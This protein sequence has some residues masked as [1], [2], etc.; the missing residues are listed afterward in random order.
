MRSIDFAS[1]YGFPESLPAEAHADRTTP[2][3]AAK[4]RAAQL[5]KDCSEMLAKAAMTDRKSPVGASA[6]RTTELD[7]VIRSIMRA[8][9]ER[10]SAQAL[11]AAGIQDAA[12]GG[13]S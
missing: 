13:Q 5:P 10:Y 4:W 2:P 9:P 8:H 6:S 3:R 11:A 7:S 1:I 12:E